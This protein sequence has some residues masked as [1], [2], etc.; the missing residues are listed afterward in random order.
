MEIL[1]EEKT[2]NRVA[3][4][5]IRLP[6]DRNWDKVGGCGRGLLSTNDSRT[7]MIDTWKN[8]T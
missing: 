1:E 7:A 3:S 6:M 4:M 8:T 2:V 5:L